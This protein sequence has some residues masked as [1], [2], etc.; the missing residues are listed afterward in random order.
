MKRK[1]ITSFLI[2]LSFTPVLYSQIDS[3]NGGIVYGKNHAFGV[4]APTGWV[5]DNKSG[6]NVGLQAVFYPAGDSWNSAVSVMYC[7][8]AL[9]EVKGNETIEK[10]IEYDI[11]IFKNKS[12]ADVKDGDNLQTDDNNTAIVKNFYDST[13]KNYETVAYI[14]EKDV[15]VL[16]VLSSRNKEDFEKSLEPFK[17]LVSSYF[18]IT[19]QVKINDK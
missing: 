5:L 6:V 15:V 17:E 11:N 8:T 9:K 4:N 2:I 10:V 14:D 16:L 12:K 18:F 3:A 1:L 13:N 19:D 7:N